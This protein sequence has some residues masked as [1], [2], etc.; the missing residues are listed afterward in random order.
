MCMDEFWISKRPKGC[1]NEVQLHV[2]LEPGDLCAISYRLTGRRIADIADC[3]RD[4]AS[5]RDLRLVDEVARSGVD[6]PMFVGIGESLERGQSLHTVRLV[7][8]HRLDQG[9]VGGIDEVQ[10][11]VAVLAA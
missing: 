3:D 4:D 10:H 9:N 7:R 6:Q 11:H 5:K 8:L 2:A 1:G